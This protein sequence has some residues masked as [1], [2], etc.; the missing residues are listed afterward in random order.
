MLY[1]DDTGV[2]SQYPEQLK[3]TMGV[4]V[5]MCPL[6]SLY[7]RPKLRSCVYVQ[8]GCRSP[9]P[10]PGVQPDERVC[11]SRGERQPHCRPVRRG[12]PAHT[13]R[14]VQLPELHPQ[15]ERPTE[16]SPRAQNPDAK[17]EVLET[18]LYGCVTWSPR[19]CHYDTLRPTDS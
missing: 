1:A 8:R 14:M 10:Y 17:S 18:M 5:V 11:I 7:R 16:H 15:T 4:I 19:A 13:Q 6:A 2:V 3:K 9:P 12:Q